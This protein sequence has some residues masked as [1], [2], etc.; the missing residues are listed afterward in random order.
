MS[1]PSNLAD[2]SLEETGQAQSFATQHSRNSSIQSTSTDCDDTTERKASKFP[3]MVRLD[4][5][6]FMA[7]LAR[8][9]SNDST[10]STTST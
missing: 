4:M 6:F 8:T 5:E 9:N 10:T 3:D 7:R 2:L 1:L